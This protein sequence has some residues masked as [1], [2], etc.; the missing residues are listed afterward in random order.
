VIQSLAAL[1]FI[2]LFL[3]LSININNI[4][5]IVLGQEVQ[6]LP[7]LLDSN[8][9]IELVSDELSD[10]TSMAFLG[11]ADILVLEKN[12]RALMFSVVC[13]Y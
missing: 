11:P 12:E 10:P 6:G 4:M 1:V 13:S 5:T 2:I 3:N 8:L 7:E 9:Q